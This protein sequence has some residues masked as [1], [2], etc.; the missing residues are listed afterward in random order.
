MRTFA[1]HRDGIRVRMSSDEIDALRIVPELLGTVGEVPH[2]PAAQR[3]EIDVYPDDLRAAE[4]FRRLMASEVESARAADRSAFTDALDA[5]EGGNT[6][7]SGDEAEA[8]LMVLG[9]ARL[10]LAARLGI[11]EEG[12]GEDEASAQEPAMAMLHYL[13]WLQGS[14]TDVLME[15]L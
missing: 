15:T 10:A 4:E 3:L 1:R 11:E 8:W 13:S 7:L 5:L 2:D 12:W 9:E 14:L 6:I